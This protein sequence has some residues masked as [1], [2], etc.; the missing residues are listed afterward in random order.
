[1]S[2]GAASSSS[3]RA[4]PPSPPILPGGPNYSITGAGFVPAATQLFLGSNP[5]PP[6]QVSVI[7]AGDTIGFTL[8]AAQPPGLVAV[9][10]RVDGV[11]APATWS[12]VVP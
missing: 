7:A 11:D 12:L 3:S 5:I 1:M 10:V 2:A 9:R 4:S 6:A 8:P